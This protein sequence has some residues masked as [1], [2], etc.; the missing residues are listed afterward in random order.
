[1]SKQLQRIPDANNRRCLQSRSHGWVT[2]V[3]QWDGW[4]V[5][6]NIVGFMTVTSALQIV[7][8]LQ[9]EC[10]EDTVQS[11]PNKA[12]GWVGLSRLDLIVRKESFDVMTEVATSVCTYCPDI[13]VTKW[14]FYEGVESKLPQLRNE[15]VI[16]Q[17]A[18]QRRLSG[19]RGMM[20]YAEVHVSAEQPHLECYPQ[21]TGFFRSR[22]RP[23]SLGRQ[24]QRLL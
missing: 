16:G 21:A 9:R 4:G 19:C 22:P 24:T 12:E 6:T 20:T 3:S 18:L 23:S 13:F 1:M 7:A 14:A 10:I 8:L 17:A 2:C 15:E 11:G 5:T